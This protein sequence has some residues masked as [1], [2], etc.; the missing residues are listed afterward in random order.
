[1][2]EDLKITEENRKLK[3]QLKVFHEKDLNEQI[4]NDNVEKEKIKRNSFYQLQMNRKG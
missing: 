2:F 3:E 1:M 4:E